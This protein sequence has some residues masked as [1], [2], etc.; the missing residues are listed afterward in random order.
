MITLFT[1]SVSLIGTHILLLA[2]SMT[3]SMI[4]IGFYIFYLIN[5]FPSTFTINRILFD[6]QYS[7]ELILSI[8]LKK[9]HALYKK[10]SSKH[11]Y[12]K[13]SALRTKCKILSETDKK[14]HINNIEFSVVNDRRAFWNHINSTTNANKLPSIMHLGDEFFSN[15]S[16]C[17][18]I[19]AQYF[20]STFSDG[21]M[22]VSDCEEA[23][24]NL[25]SDLF[26]F[27][28]FTISLAEIFEY[29][30]RLNCKKGAGTNLIPN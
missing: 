26:Q 19:F 16:D 1:I 22:S 5:L 14:T 7:R 25:Q 30:A 15:N 9:H 29:I 12:A 2:T 4:F 27:D 28:L 24:S 23:V 3:T 18:Q 17:S 20:K 10:Y 11:S 6:L 8:K 21:S 13:F